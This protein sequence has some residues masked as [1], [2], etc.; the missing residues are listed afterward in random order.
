MVQH[1]SVLHFHCMCVHSLIIHSPTGI[2]LI[3]SLFD[4]HQDCFLILATMNK[5]AMNIH[6]QVCV[7]VSFF[8][9]I[10]LEVE[11]LGHMVNLCLT[12]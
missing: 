2:L 9:D 4:G 8:L 10:Y 6:M 7:Y 3:P 5:A 11:L 1:V 12:F